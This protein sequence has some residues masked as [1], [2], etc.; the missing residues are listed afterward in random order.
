MV[1]GLVSMVAGCA[2]SGFDLEKAAPDTTNITG[3][4]SKAVQTTPDSSKLSDQNTIRNVVSALNFTQWGKTPIPW[5]NADTGS[6]GTITT[7]AETKNAAGLCREFE[8]SREAFDGAALYR[9]QACMAEG[10]NWALTS[11]AQL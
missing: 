6:Q 7:V 5:A 2:M 8:T 11:F 9:G 3:S 4:V 10:G 1:F